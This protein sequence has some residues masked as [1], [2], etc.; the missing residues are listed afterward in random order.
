MRECSVLGN[1]QS[2]V[3]RAVL[4]ALLPYQQSRR[5]AL[6]QPNTGHTILVMSK[7]AAAF[8]PISKSR[9]RRPGGRLAAAEFKARCLELMDRVR[10]TGAEYVVTKHGKPVAKLVP[11]CADSTDLIGS[12]KGK[13]EIHGDILSTGIEWDAES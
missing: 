12:L 6:T 7:K 5:G 1:R 9:G 3:A 8:A 13:I 11:I 10:E 2:E 4:T